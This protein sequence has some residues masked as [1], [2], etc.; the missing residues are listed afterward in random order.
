MDLVKIGKIISEARKRKGFTQKEL[1]NKLHISDKAISKWE[2]GIGSPDISFIIPLSQI[3]DISLYELLSGEKEEVEETIK[4]TLRYS[5]KE[6]KR[7]NKQHKQKTFIIT[8]II[9]LLFFVFGYKV[10]NLI[11]YNTNGINKEEY[12][13]LIEGYQVKDVEEI[14][15]NRLDDSLYISYKGVKIKN[16]FDGFECSEENGFIRYYNKEEN[17]Y[18]SFGTTERYVDYLD[19]E[20]DVFGI[21]SVAFDSI[22]KTNMLSSIETDLELF[23]YF[24]ENRNKSVNIFS[25]INEI[26]NNYYIKYISYIM[27]PSIEYITEL[28]G[29]LDGYILNLNED[30]NK[31]LKEVNIIH[32]NKRYAMLMVGFDNKEVLEIL[33]T[34]IIDEL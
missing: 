20:K 18:L 7:K 9:V 33:S 19:K 15:T 17:K 24:Y 16:L 11:F 5:S 3:L 29:D 27:L 32:N 12:L 34:L 25:S 14:N 2:R 26:K 8:T 23:K 6:I 4:N 1:A 13:N 10:F 30:F 21:N 31:N 28:R 22:A